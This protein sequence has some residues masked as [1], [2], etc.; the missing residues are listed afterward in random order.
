MPFGK[1][2]SL[3]AHIN[4]IF[5]GRKI[6]I[7]FVLFVAQRIVSLFP[8]RIAET[9]FFLLLRHIQLIFCN[10]GAGDTVL[11]IDG[12]AIQL[13]MRCLH[14][15]KSVADSALPRVMSGGK[16]LEHI[17]NIK[18][19][20]TVEMNSAAENSRAVLVFKDN[21]C[22][23]N[24]RLKR[25][26]VCDL[27]SVQFIN[28]FRHFFSSEEFFCKTGKERFIPKSVLCEIYKIHHRN[29]IEI[30]GVGTKINVGF[31]EFGKNDNVV[32]HSRTFGNKIDVRY[33]HGRKA[34]LPLPDFIIA[35]KQIN[36]FIFPADIKIRKRFYFSDKIEYFFYGLPNACKQFVTV[37]FRIQSVIQIIE[38]IAR[39]KN[40][41][42][43]VGGDV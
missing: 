5:G 35:E 34:A 31:Y 43:L 33:R 4:I 27:S 24:S 13:L 36:M 19:E 25:K 11:R 40:V 32:M 23:P 6:F 21:R 3:I 16:P 20:H 30:E 28:P 39:L 22:H 38:F 2:D 12:A 26:I 10:I 42:Q 18:I 9:V 17:G 37:I 29:L 7:G 41:E 15:E 8:N 14:K 1:L